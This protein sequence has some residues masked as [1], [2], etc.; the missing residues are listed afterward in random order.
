MDQD[1]LEA[2]A[3]LV[4]GGLTAS[5]VLTELNKVSDFEG[6]LPQLRTLQRV[7]SDIRGSMTINDGEFRWGNLDDYDIPWEASEY[8][9]DLWVFAKRGRYK[10]Y[11]KFENPLLSVREVKWW[12]RVHL[13]D[14]RLD[15]E[16]VMGVSQLFVER[17]LIHE[18]LKMPRDMA[19]L[20]A[21]LAFKPWRSEEFGAIY[22]EAV[23]S[24][25][26]P[27]LKVISIE[28]GS[29]LIQELPVEAYQRYIP[30]IV[31]GSHP[32]T[33]F[34]EVKMTREDN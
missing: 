28:T 11:S 14:Q 6:R 9:L 20:E 23:D 33:I 15:T 3:N 24:K 2:I 12:W 29:R 22:F 8:L 26:I 16:G 32:D 13:A 4:H 17:E 34:P 7:V 5:K 10:S 27:A 19:D 30:S 1:V 21:L 18:V 31:R 25:R